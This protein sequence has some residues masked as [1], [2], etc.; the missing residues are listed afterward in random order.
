MPDN[1]RQVSQNSQQYTLGDRKFIGIN[2]NLPPNSLDVGFAQDITNM[3]VDGTSLSPRPGWQAQL[4]STLGAPIYAMTK[5]RT[6]DNVSNKILFVSGSTLYAHTIGLASAP[7]SLGTGTWTDAS[8]VRLIQHG[9]Y[10]Y[11]CPGKDGTAMFRTDGTN[12]L[13]KIP[14]IKPPT[15][16]GKTAVKPLATVVPNIIKT[17]NAKAK[18]DSTYAAVRSKPVLTN[19]PTVWS[20]NLMKNSTGA[21]T[22][23]AGE[24]DGYFTGGSINNTN[25]IADWQVSGASVHTAEAWEGDKSK[26][27]GFPA[28]SP[29]FTGFT[30]KVY[31]KLDNA[32]EY[33]EHVVQALP[34]EYYP[35]SST[36]VTMGLYNLQ[37]YS[38]ANIVKSEGSVR[39]SVSVNGQDSSGDLFGAV[40]SKEYTQAVPVNET[41]W[42]LRNIIIDF[43]EFAQYVTKL[44]IRFTS[45]ATIAQQ[46]IL[47]DQVRCWAVAS[48]FDV[49]NTTETDLDINGLVNIRFNQSNPNLG[50]MH[51]SYVKDKR[52][53]IINTNDASVQLNLETINSISFAWD[54]DPLLVSEAKA[55]PNVVLGLQTGS[56]TTIA[57][58]SIGIWDYTN[59]FLT[60]NLFGLTK[61]QKTNISN[62]FV[63][64][65]QD[66]FRVDNN[67]AFDS[68]SRSYSIGSMNKD[69]GLGADQT[70][71]YAFTLW[72]PESATALA[73]FEKLADDT[74]S[75]GYETSLSAVSNTVTA[76]A[77]LSTASIVLN[78]DNTSTKGTNIGRGKHPMT[79]VASADQ[80]NQDFWVSTFV[81]GA[82][83]IRLVSST[84]SPSITYIAL[85]ASTVTVSSGSFTATTGADGTV[86]Y[87]YT[88]P[89]TNAGRVKYVTAVTGTIWLEHYV[90]YGYTDTTTYS[91]VIVYRRNSSIFPDGRFRLI[92]V[93]PY[94][95]SSSTATTVTGANW[96]ATYNNS[97]SREIVL[98]D[99][100]VDSDL[101]YVTGDYQPGFFYQI[102]RDALPLGASSVATFQGRLWMSKGN[103]VTASW[104]LDPSYEYGMYTTEFPDFTEPSVIRKGMQFTVGGSQEKEIV[105]AMI[106]QF[107]DEIQQSTSTSAALIILKEN[108]LSAVTG[109]DPTTFTVQ[110]WIAT[111]G[112]GIA[113]PN[114]LSNTYGTVTW[115]AVNGIVAYER[116][117]IVPRSTELR[118]LLSLDPTM[119][120]PASIDKTYYQQSLSTTAN[121]R[122]FVVSTSSGA[123]AANK[124]IYVFDSRTR[125]WVKWTT[126]GSVS[127]SS[128]TTLAFSDDIQYVYAGSADGQIY[129]L[130]GTA[131]KTTAG[132][133]DIDI[134]WSLTTRQHGQTYS[135][136]IAYYALNKPVQ[137]DLH[138]ENI[139][140][141][142]AST[143]TL[144]MNWSIQ[145]QNGSYVAITNPYGISTSGTWYF[146]QKAN[147]TSAVRNLGRDVKGQALQMNLSGSSTGTF[148][149]HGVH[150]HCYDANVPR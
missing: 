43:R 122:L 44:R 48:D 78:P 144:E 42:E 133:A 147:T 116:G 37:F 40:F 26:T 83:Q 61:A 30:T 17:I 123:S 101:Y 98:N 132:G 94:S 146:N 86:Y 135:E 55:Y 95:E 20:N 127:F 104:L 3:W 66:A 14:Q 75:R 6:A 92:A 50:T 145:N 114:T 33:A 118:K 27:I 124:T 69:I 52:I 63:K 71:E 38:F 117:S 102:G 136:G 141:F 100:V 58:S 25:F 15:T 54:F 64:F 93:I 130:V 126:P 115:L 29:T 16:D 73:P 119:G 9:K 105:R 79:V 109:F 96:T 11:G 4:T 23:P 81:P 80:T 35:P 84:A 59:K 149:L 77:A 8:Q 56:T 106:S 150:V 138:V 76:T 128:I 39:F 91:H 32:G 72:Y 22:V 90:P 140:A 31:M 89:A 85:D 70:Y 45:T 21:A 110:M 68:R 65:T 87:A 67:N 7:A 111:P 125:G 62:V 103:L 24:F 19:W 82:S 53:R 121:Q 97:S 47:I 148:Y 107:S 1:S 134:S 139:N 88:I 137:L 2:T 41:G 60:F 34:Q 143:T 12:A 36:P 131:D 120:G 142:K 46:D 57:W 113:A 10:V 74:Y 108:S 112:A 99:V 129:K 51:A 5:F 49:S 28:G 18:I 13:E